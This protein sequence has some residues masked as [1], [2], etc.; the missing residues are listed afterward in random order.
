[1]KFHFGKLNIFL[2]AVALILLTVGYIIMGNGDKTISPILLVLSYA[3]L[4]PLSFILGFK[5]KDQE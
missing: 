2:L 1:M 4:L 3:V 5:N